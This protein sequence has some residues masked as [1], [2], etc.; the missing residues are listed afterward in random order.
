LTEEAAPEPLVPAGNPFRPKSALFAALAALVPFGLMTANIHSPL[1]V[2]IG[3]A[4]CLVAG[5][6][7]LDVLGAFDDESEREAVPLRAL[8]PRLIELVGSLVLVVAAM[9]LAVAGRLPLGVITSGLLV[10]GGL[11]W[12]MIAGYRVLEGLGAVAPDRP[13][14]RRAGF[15]LTCVGVV[16]YLP[17]LGSFSLT[18]PWETHYGEVAREMLSRDDWISTFW[19][20]EGFFWS[21]PV[22]DFWLQALSFSAFGVEFRPDQMLASAANGLTPRPEWAA[23]L[24]ITLLTLLSVWLLYRAVRKSVG[25]RPAFLGGVVL[26]TLPYWYLL[27]RQ[28]MT[29]MPYVA[30]LTAALALLFLGLE[31]DPDA[32]VKV[33]PLA[34]GRRT[35]GLSA[36]HALFLLII[37][38]VLPQL[39][40]LASRH[41]TLE[42]FASPRGFLF[43]WDRVLL[44]SLGNCDL[45]G[46]EACRYVGPA[47]PAFQPATGALLWAGVAGFFLWLNRGERRVQ[48]LLFLAAWYFTALSALAKG[49]PGLVLPVLIAVGHLLATRRFR[50]LGRLELPALGLLV[51]AVCLPWYAQM[52][53][54]HGAPFTDRLL[55]HDMYKRAFVHVHDTNTGDDISFRYYVWQLGYGLFPWTGLAAA[56]LVYSTQVGRN[57]AKTKTGAPDAELLSAL[58]LWFILAFAMFTVSLT[59]FHHYIFPAVPPLAMLSGVMLDRLLPERDPP[60]RSG[61]AWAGCLVLSALFLLYGCVRLL[62]GSVLGDA[63]VEAAA[64]NVVGVVSM[65]LGAALFVLGVRRFSAPPGSLTTDG[66][67]FSSAAISVCALASAGVLLLVGRDLSTHGEV[68][69]AARFIHLISYNYERLWPDTLDFAASFRAISLV[70]AF[71]CLLI[72]V[73]AV[74][75]HGAALLLSVGLWSAVFALNVYFVRIAPHWGQRETVFAYYKARK[76]ATEPLVAYQMN[77]KGENFYTGNH[78][79]AFVTTGERFKSWVG[80]QKRRGVRVMFF[81]TE[82]SRE[83]S[84]KRELGPTKKYERV[85][86]RALNNKFFV[87]RVEL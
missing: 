1:S 70:S 83:R 68:E 35:F 50:D 86:T 18:D 47:E 39:L 51:A 32:K 20:Q 28:S 71:A 48:R 49:A 85:T 27:A 52:Y 34:I 46:N 3:L 84:L 31:S 25:T 10:S 38:T 74:R 19:A 53:A 82:H 76:D 41:I 44:G 59:K 72:A 16:L 40:Y 81:T 69:G 7:L 67:R 23:R 6:F 37:V 61:L 54:R 56:G 2:P 75:A 65:S 13:L 30:P 77:W 79:P 15:V 80:E 78:L 42:L 26:L 58:L 43:H 14:A 60:L 45:P 36:Y 5:F 73:R 64:P 62:G 12:A 21:K 66:E 24:P 55:F 33:F 8:A 11:V 63:V 29:D 9:R 87:A 57:G 22:L 17:M 4:G